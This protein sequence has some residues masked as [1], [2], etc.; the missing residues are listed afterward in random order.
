MFRTPKLRLIRLRGID[1]FLHPAVRMLPWKITYRWYV[2]FA[3]K[4]W[5]EGIRFIN[6]EP[7]KVRAMV[8]RINW[9]IASRRIKP[10]NERAKLAEHTDSC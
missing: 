10:I 3:F 2:L 6:E 7:A 4:T 8:S 1:P 9:L 5:E